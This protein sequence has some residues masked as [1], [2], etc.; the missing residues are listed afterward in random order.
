M[1]IYEADREMQYR[2]CWTR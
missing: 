2:V 1:M